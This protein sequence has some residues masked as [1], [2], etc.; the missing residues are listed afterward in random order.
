M[1]SSNFYWSRRLIKGF[2]KM[3]FLIAPQEA[4]ATGGGTSLLGSV[5][6]ELSGG[7]FPGRGGI[8]GRDFPEPHHLTTPR[9]ILNAIESR[10]QDLNFKPDEPIVLE[11]KFP[12]LNLVFE[13]KTVSKSGI[14]N[15]PSLPVTFNIDYSRLEKLFIQFGDNTRKLYIPTGYLTRL[16]NAV[17]GDDAQL[18]TD[19]NIDKETIVHQILL[20]DRYSLTFESTSAF[21]SNFE[22]AVNLA[23]T[24]NAG[25]VSF[26]LEQATR[27]QVT[28][29]VNDGKDYL[30]ALRDID[31]DD[32]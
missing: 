6:N 18:S 7:F 11:M 28:V 25:N 30:I 10:R 8:I 21:D 14:G 5:V 4:D 12:K 32:F 22:A 3:W 24:L 16:K 29:N 1:S 15:F 31:W 2:G 27:R 9:L 26:E 20:T 19:V 13:K 17:D 23:N